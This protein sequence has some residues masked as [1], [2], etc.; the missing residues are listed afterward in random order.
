MEFEP[1]NIMGNLTWRTWLVLRY[2]LPYHGGYLMPVYTIQWRNEGTLYNWDVPASSLEEAK[3][4]TM[5]A[6][7]IRASQILKEGAWR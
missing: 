1:L 4:K 2:I 6:H 3:R 5:E 7:G